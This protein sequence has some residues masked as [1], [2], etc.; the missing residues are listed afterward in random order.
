MPTRLR[1]TALVALLAAVSGCGAI[2]QIRY[3][4]AEIA[5]RAIVVECALSADFR[6]QNL[7]AING[8]L[9][10]NVYT[11]RAMALDCDGDG[12]SDF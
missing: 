7:T 8:W 12:S 4:A 9:T 1:L 6:R 5:G 10:T 2:D 11:P 3:T